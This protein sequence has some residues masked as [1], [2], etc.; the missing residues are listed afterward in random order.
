MNKTNEENLNFSA[1]VSR[2]LDIVANALYSHNDVFLREL[3]SNASDACDRLRYESL[4]QPE[5]NKGNQ[6]LHIRVF[7]DTDKRTLTVIDNGI[8]MNREELIDNLGTI[9]KSGTSAIMSELQNKKE[10]AD[11]LKLIGQFGVGFYSCF[12]VSQKSEVISCRAGE[13]KI[14][15]WES[16]GR[17]GYKIR[18]AD[19]NE[20]AMLEGT[21]GTAVIL[22][23]NK[24]ASDFLV[25]EKI[26][27]VIQRYSD[28]IAFPIFLG[29]KEESDKEEEPVNT[30]TAIWMRPKDEVTEEQYSEFYHHITYAIDD[31]LLT[32]HWRAEG[33]IEFSSLLFIPTM[34]P[35]DLYDPSR[36]NAV[37]LYVRRVF[38]TDQCETLIYPWLRFLRG[39]IDSEDLPLNIS[40]ESLQFNPVISKIRKAV[41][42][43]V[44]SELDRL[45]KDVKPAFM[46][47]WH[48]FGAALKEGLYDAYELRGEIFKVARFYS[49]HSD[50]ELVSLEEYLSRMKEGQEHIYYITGENIETLRNSPQTEGFKE[51]GLEVLFMTDTIDDFWLQAVPDYGGKQFR[52]ITKGTIDLDKFGKENAGEDTDKKKEEKKDNDAVNNLVSKLAEI[53]KEDVGQVRLSSRLSSSPVCLI[54]A[55]NEADLNMERVLRI[56]QKYEPE[57]KRILEINGGHPLIVKLSGLASGSGEGTQNDLT[58]AAHLLLDQAR[59]IQGEPLPDPAAFSRRMSA[60]LARGLVAA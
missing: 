11:P 6:P 16:D 52:S 25:D 29:E 54:A 9:A 30:V 32:L 21:S 1:D 33:T 8:G 45:S 24:E 55:D 60:F 10:E 7:K 51:R 20:A 34:R 14:W 50:E 53:L 47:F 46:T 59:I 28:H 42:K 13:K 18:E 4:V 2:L 22:H 36:K 37:K 31:P 56:H 23:L 40:R 57:S 17:T 19:E 15:H 41:A 49:T 26:K 5:I 48:Q 39:V 12:M 38:I 35:W 44:L 3:I 43:K 58:D 27:L